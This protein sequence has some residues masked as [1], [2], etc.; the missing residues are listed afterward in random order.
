M[1]RTRNPRRAYDAD[2]REITPMDLANMRQ[3]DG[4]PGVWLRERPDG[5]RKEA[6][7]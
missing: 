7:T 6:E 2:G 5:G 3:N 1:K 4:G